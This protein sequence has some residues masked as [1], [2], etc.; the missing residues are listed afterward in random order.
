MEKIDQVK[1]Y[2]C[3]KTGIPKELLIGDTVEENVSRAIALL[4]YRSEK[5]AFVKKE[6]KKSTSEQFAEWMEAKEGIE[7]PDPYTE[8]INELKNDL[9]PQPVA[10]IVK[11]T[12]VDS[13]IPEYKG[14]TKEQF[15][16]WFRSRGF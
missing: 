7:R 11:D 16:S 6:E 14:S 9:L 13:E 4:S 2:I 15:A 12:S 10:P 1:E 5:E 8:M 3:Q